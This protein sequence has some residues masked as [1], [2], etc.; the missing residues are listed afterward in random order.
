[1]PPWLLSFLQMAMQPRQQPQF[2][3]MYGLPDAV[4]QSLMTQPSYAEGQIMAPEQWWNQAMGGQLQMM[5]PQRENR[6]MFD[7]NEALGIPNQDTVNPWS[8]AMPEGGMWS[9]RPPGVSPYASPPGRGF[10]LGLY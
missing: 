9:S 10:P 5:G 2:D 6:L 7:R 1:M 3:P 8:W 4:R